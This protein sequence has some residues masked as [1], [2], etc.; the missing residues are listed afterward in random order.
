[1]YDKIK[2]YMG[3]HNVLSKE[4]ILR[5][6]HRKK[7]DEEYLQKQKELTERNMD[8][9]Q[10]KRNEKLKAAIAKEE[11]IKA[12]LENE[13]L[14]EKQMKE[15]NELE[16]HREKIVKLDMKLHKKDYSINEHKDYKDLVNKYKM[17]TDEITELRAINEKID[18]LQKQLEQSERENTELLKK[19][20]ALK[21]KRK[22]RRRKLKISPKK[23]NLTEDDKLKGWNMTDWTRHLGSLDNVKLLNDPDTYPYS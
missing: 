19:I 3:F 11:L 18:N 12:K 10:K 17:K 13:K 22:L 7:Q 16:N 15:L 4:E 14:A 1:M 6:E 2:K 20:Y 21:G 23:F 8:K 5:Y 9:E